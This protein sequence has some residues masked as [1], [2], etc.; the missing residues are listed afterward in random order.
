MFGSWII[1]A[2]IPAIRSWAAWAVVSGASVATQTEAGTIGFEPH[3]SPSRT[4][5]EPMLHELLL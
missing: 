2:T 4:L 1:M 3:S 5:C